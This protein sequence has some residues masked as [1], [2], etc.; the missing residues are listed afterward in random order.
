MYIFLKNII[1]QLMLDRKNF[2]FQMITKEIDNYNAYC[3]TLIVRSEYPKY[4]KVIVKKYINVLK[5]TP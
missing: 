1:P 4:N 3:Y 5:T 2:L